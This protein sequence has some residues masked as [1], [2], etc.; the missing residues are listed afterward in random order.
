MLQDRGFR[1]EI[2]HSPDGEP[3]SAFMSLISAAEQRSIVR[4]TGG[5]AEMS[6]G[7]AQ[8]LE[9]LFRDA[10][11]G[12]KGALLVGGTRMVLT[13]DMSTRVTGITDVGP[14]IRDANA[15]SILLGV[16]G[17]ADSLSWDYDAAALIIE[18]SE[19]SDPADRSASRVATI[20]QPSMDAVAI[21]AKRITKQSIW[22]D[23]AVFCAKVTEAQ[24]VYARWDSA[25]VVYNGGGTTEFEVRLIAEQ[26]WPVVL[27]RG[28]GRKADELAGDQAFLAR[29]RNVIVC[30]KEAMSLRSA[31]V[32]AGVIDPPPARGR[33]KAVS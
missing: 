7:D 21:L 16:V 2:L 28:S 22:H 26:G 1:A 4:I 18:R 10:F 17:R 30:D 31:L 9:A 27:I 32:E 33:L 24:R 13:E 20:V 19:F 15:A 8:D 3:P 14:V 29:F 6:D 12:F 11:T 5:C 25:L 23:E